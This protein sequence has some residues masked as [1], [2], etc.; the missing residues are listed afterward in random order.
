MASITINDLP[1]H[2]ALDRRAMSLIR[3]A[4]SGLWLFGWIRM[5]QDALPSQPMVVNFYEINNFADQMI[6]QFQ[7]VNVSN[8]APNSTLNVAVDEHSVN[9]RF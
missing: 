6:N 8:S 9:N 1:A 3:G 4:K 7:M 2:S 5:H